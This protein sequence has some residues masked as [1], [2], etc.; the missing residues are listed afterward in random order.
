[1]SIFTFLFFVG[2]SSEAGYCE[3]EEVS[4]NADQE[5]FIGSTPQDLL[6]LIPATGTYGLQWKYDSNTCL[7]YT[8]EW[9]LDTAKEIDET[10]VPSKVRGVEMLRVGVDPITDPVCEPYV[11]ISGMITITSIHGE[12]DEKMPVEAYFY[13]GDTGIYGGFDATTN[14]LNGTYEPDCGTQDCYENASVEFSFSGG[15]SDDKMY[16]SFF[17][18]KYNDDGSRAGWKLASWGTD[19]DDACES[20]Q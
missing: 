13:V 11:T 19:Y 16:G 15:L 10:L 20:P 9:E 1:M 14:T 2:C 17:I 3:V 5:T 4:V 7:S 12:F 18:D 8:L 6:S